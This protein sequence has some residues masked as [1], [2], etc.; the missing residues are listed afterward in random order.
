MRRG[1]AGFGGK[2]RVQLEKREVEVNQRFL[3][4]RKVH[5]YVVADDNTLFIDAF[6]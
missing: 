1:A 3:V 2:L 6:A 4:E 5:L